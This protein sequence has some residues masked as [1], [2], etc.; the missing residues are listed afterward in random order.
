MQK[1]FI[2][3]VA[4]ILIGVTIPMGFSSDSDSV[5]I[6]YGETAQANHE[7]KE[8]VNNY[9][10]NNTNV[11]VGSTNNKV[12]SAKN[13]NDVFNSFTNKSYSI[14]Q[15]YSSCLVDMNRDVDLSVNL[16]SSKIT[17]ITSD[18]YES[19]LKSAG[20]TK[21]TIYL[22]SPV[23][24]DG[25]NVLAEVLDSYESM[26]NMEIP[27]NVKVA[28]NREIYVQAEIVKNSNMTPENLTKLVSTVKSDIIDGNVDNHTEVV[29]IIDR[30]VKKNNLTMSNSD[31]ENL[32]YTLEEVKSVQNDAKNY[33]REISDFL[34]GNKTGVLSIYNF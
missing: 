15:I 1:K 17:L 29:K 12:F 10:T 34:S 33:E 9:F 2:A 11:D 13:A 5:V 21:G 20:I 22:T 14:D 18:M 8:I 28:A 7:Y 23:D 16:D 27:N 25:E 4:L 6:T 3:F 30:Y 24:I 19:A 32:A 31:V 26:T